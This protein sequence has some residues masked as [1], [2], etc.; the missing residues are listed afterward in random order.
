MALPGGKQ[1]RR[2]LLEPWSNHL[3][4]G[5][6]FECSTLELVGWIEQDGDRY[7]SKGDHPLGPQIRVPVVVTTHGITKQLNRLHVADS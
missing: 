3:T 5:L 6:Y 2:A 7:F 1:D 4:S